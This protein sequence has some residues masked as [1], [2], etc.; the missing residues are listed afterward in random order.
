MIVGDGKD[1]ELFKE[2]NRKTGNYDVEFVG[3]HEP[4]TFYQK[5][6]IL[7]I[8]SSYEGS[9]C[10]IQEALYHNVIPIAF[11]SFEASS[12]YII[13]SKTGFLINAFKINKYAK[14]LKKLMVENTIIQEIQENIKKE[15]YLDQFSIDNIIK[16]WEQLFRK[17][18]Q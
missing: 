18:I 10:V 12:D 14:V 11:D 17:L 1:I 6:K 2:I 7:C 4:T 13:N 16:Q 5:S 8:V 3:F 15:N 9:P